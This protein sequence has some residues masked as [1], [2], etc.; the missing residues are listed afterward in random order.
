MNTVLPAADFLRIRSLR[1]VA[2][3]TT[4]MFLCAAASVASAQ[5]AFKTPDEAAERP[6][7]RGQD[8]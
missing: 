6:C 1:K 7:Q 5:Q 3:F 2:S 8:R 4:A